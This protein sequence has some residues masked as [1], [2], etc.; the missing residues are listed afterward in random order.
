[1]KAI[2]IFENTN[3]EMS[4]AKEFAASMLI[5]SAKARIYWRFVVMTDVIW[6]YQIPTAATDGIYIYINPDFF[7]GLE[8]DSQRA[9]LLGHEVGH[10]VLKHQQRGSAFEKRGY[11][12]MVKGEK[13]PFSHSLYNEAADYVINADLIAHGLEFIKSGLLDERFDRD[14]LVDEVYFEL[15]QEQKDKNTGDESGESSDSEPS[16]SDDNQAAESESAENNDESENETSDKEDS[17]KEGSSNEPSDSTEESANAGTGGD[18]HDVH[19]SPQYAGSDEEIEDAKKEDEADLDRTLTDGIADQQEAIDQKE[20]KDIGASKNVGA[21]LSASQ[22]RKSA[23]LSWREELSDLMQNSGNGDK[24]TWSKIH[25]RR[26]NLLGVIT[27]TLRGSVDKLAITVDVSY[28]VDRDAL[29]QF[30]HV[31]ADVID[32]LMP[33]EGALI[34][35]VSD[36]IAGV[37]EVYTGSELLDLEIPAGGGTHLSCTID[38]MESEGHNAD[39]HLVF[40]DGEI[41]RSDAEKLVRDDAVF[42]LDSV[43]CRYVREILEQTEARVIVADDESLAA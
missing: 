28:S 25:K 20:H 12:R 13:I 36:H 30:M 27:P 8:S 41:A 9:F 29:S 31:V 4:D 11:F 37:H 6:S 23:P 16:E 43:P 14:H 10:M 22:H 34:M 3:P 26:F 19:L 15:Q 21:A 5:L 1:M 7:V 40:T 39:I 33:S 32:D 38:H 24:Q 35:F 17:K 2:K 42:V 18:G